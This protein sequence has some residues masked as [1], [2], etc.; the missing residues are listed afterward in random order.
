MEFLATF[1]KGGVH[2]KDK[3]ELANRQP[4]E[5]FTA[6]DELIVPLSQHTGSPAKA[7]K[8]KGDTVIAGEKIGESTG[9]I[10]ANIHSPVNGTISDIKKITLANSIVS[11]AFVI[12]VDNENPFGEWVE[13]A[14]KEYTSSE[15][16]EIVKEMG[17]VGAGGAAFPTH[18]KL[19]IPRGRRVNDL[20]INGV[21][22][23]PYLTADHRLMVE[24]TAELLKG[25]LYVAKIVNPQR[26]T[27]GVENN[28]RDAI[29]ALRQVISSNDYPIEVV[30]LKVKYPQGDEKQLLKAIIKREVP[31][32]KLPLDVEAVVVNVGTAYA[33][34][35]AVAL[36]K[37]FIE[38][39]V[40]LSGE[41]VKH[42][43]NLLVPIGTKV[44][45]LLAVAECDDVENYIA[46][47]PMMGFAF[48]DATTP[49][50]KGTSGILA[51]SPKKARVTTPC[52]SCGRCIT[53]CPMGLQPTKLYRL[54]DHAQYE[55]A[56]ANNLMDCKECG[57]CAY[58][59][60]AHLPLVHGM[61]LGKRLG[62]K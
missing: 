22:C 55:E 30:P 31:S 37:P 39:I 48:W 11:D 35:E 52:I 29:A 33:I 19:S 12:A 41:N 1:R 7:L 32:G 8:A 17:I 9:F 53:A 58:I 60:P 4:I 47:G 50:T 5:P 28:K 25:I 18:V 13:Q 54:I 51:L 61:K 20:V 43:K 24:R 2:P 34:W 56:M 57:C 3:K 42:K 15:L 26:I 10:S 27:I 62:R 23:E 44:E 21:E 46:G 16:L 40:T 6:V 45:D 14:E 38:R 59:C 36:N 49:I